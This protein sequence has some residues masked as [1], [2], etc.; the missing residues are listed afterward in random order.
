MAK[1][2]EID[3][4]AAAAIS[5]PSP[6]SFVPQITIGAFTLTDAMHDVITAV[7]ADRRMSRASVTCSRGGIDAAIRKFAEHFAPTVLLVEVGDDQAT[8][9]AELDSLAEACPPET[10][11]VVLGACNDV[12]L[13]RDMRRAGISEYLVTPVTPLDLIETLAALFETDVVEKRANVTAFFGA[14]GGC[15]SSTLA[16][17]TALALASTCHSPTLL[18]DFDLAGGTAALRLDLEAVA[19]VKSALKEGGRLDRAALDRMVLRKDGG[20]ALLA[21]PADLTDIYNYETSDIRRLIDVSRGMASHV[22]LDLPSGWTNYVAGFME[23]ADQIVLVATPDL[24]SLRNCGR[25]VALL[26]KVRPNDPPPRV[27]LS[28]T[29]IPRNQQVPPQQ[30]AKSLGLPISVEV[31]FDAALFSAAENEGQLMMQK[32]PGSV[33]G[34]RVAMIA[35]A[36]NGQTDG[37][38][39][40]ARPS[41]MNRLFRRLH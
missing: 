35:S 24:V 41:M 3:K 40:M 28:Q 15:G 23:L 31:P 34:R 18:I 20:F 21:S 19:T 5:A 29:G 2:E 10:L 11:V 7:A 13:Y 36:L 6:A 27:V 38:G 17:N 22:V 9:M 12:R 37:R 25:I 14:R 32:A 8:L 33:P 30:F 1:F 16:Q 4:S 39:V 26:R